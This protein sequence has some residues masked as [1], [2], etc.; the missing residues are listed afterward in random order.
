MN[1]IRW[2]G[3]TLVLLGT[4]LIVM[5]A[6]PG[7]ARRI[8][9]A[10]RG[11]YI[12]NVRESLED[13][14]SLATLSEAF[15]K[16]AQV[17][18][19]SV[20]HIQ[21]SM[22]QNARTRRG[23]PDEDLLRR[24]FGPH[25][26]QDAPFDDQ[27]DDRGS[28]QENFDRYD[29]PSPNAN[30]SGW[31]YD[32]EGHIITN[33]HVVG[34]AERIQVR[35]HD[36]SQ[37]TA[38]VLDSDLQTDIAI[39]KVEGGNLHPATRAQEPVQQGDIVFAFGSPFQFLFSMSQGIVSG[40][41]RQLYIIPGGY[42][43]FIQTDAAINPGNSGGPLTNIYGHVVGM[44]TAIATRTGTYNGL[45][46]AIP[47]DMVTDVVDQLLAEGKVSRGF[48]GIDLG[49]RELDEKLA[50]T[51]GFEGKGI[52]VHAVMP[53]F[54]AEQAGLQAG[55]IITKID[56]TQ[57]RTRAQLRNLVASYKPDST[58]Q[59]EVFRDGKTRTID[60]T[61][62]AIP[63]RLARGGRPAP[64]GPD[65]PDARED[66]L[67]VLRKVGILDATALDAQ[68]A[69]RVG[70]QTTSGV[71]VQRVRPG[72]AAMAAGIS[73]RTVITH[74]MDTPITTVDELVQELQKHD[75]T[76]GVRM[77]IVRL[78]GDREQPQYVLLELPSE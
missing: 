70:L 39:L 54:P 4:M 48:L 31:V 29:V 76:K 5:I 37:R 11:Q 24:F 15:R 68:V 7:L 62:T 33:Y 74:A 22:R 14:G 60:V 63:E 47:V 72:S 25:F 10:R 17:V 27:E 40:K 51:F 28:D 65:Q 61:L 59:M 67:L 6:G 2:Y 56:D 35:F 38:T 23:M 44:N 41:G 53:G 45:G 18:E 13:T 9:H 57:V 3:P 77:R 73:P 16:V 75:L 50:R 55:D 21:V 49:E 58:I 71:L 78:T 66:D 20:V 1:R 42:E 43:Q 46:F 32:E 69:D 34:N 30:G 26:R 64:P 19:P 8:E 52:L 36:G 12:T